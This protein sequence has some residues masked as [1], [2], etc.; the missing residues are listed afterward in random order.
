M[1]GCKDCTKFHRRAQKAEAELQKLKTKPTTWD[2]TERI[3]EARER[4]EMMNTLER[5]K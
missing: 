1:K 3:I 2:S 5:F 4:D